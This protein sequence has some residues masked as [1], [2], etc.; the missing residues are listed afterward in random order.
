MQLW[1][2]WTFQAGLQRSSLLCFRKPQP[3]ELGIVRHGTVASRGAI[4]A[5]S[6]TASAQTHAQSLQRN[7]SA[8]MS[9]LELVEAAGSTG[10]LAPAARRPFP[11]PSTTRELSADPSHAEALQTSQGDSS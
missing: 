7:R 6:K 2:T 4:S 10:H 8:P 11:S 5:R 3:D 1:E 9:Q